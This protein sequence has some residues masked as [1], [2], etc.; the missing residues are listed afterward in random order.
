MVAN[1]S[2]VTTRSHIARK[3]EREGK[4]GEITYLSAVSELLAV[5]SLRDIA[6]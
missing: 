2:L 6:L 5:K 4:T 1:V 3:S